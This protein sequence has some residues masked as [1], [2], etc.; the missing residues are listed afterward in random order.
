MVKDKSHINK[1]L[2]IA[3]ILILFNILTRVI[4][5]E[6][7]EWPIFVFASIIIIG[8]TIAIKIHDKN[9][10][11]INSFGLL[12]SYGFKIAAVIAC[13]YF[14]YLILAINI[15]F[16]EFINE[17][18]NRKLIE[19]KNQ[20]LVNGNDQTKNLESTVAMAKKVVTYTYLAGTLIG[21]LFI[22]VIG[23]TIGSVI[24]TKNK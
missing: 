22:G 3:V 2:I 23:S 12:F 9:S 21:T 15:F 11:S 4:N 6:F 1:G 13:I 5:A 24:V 20:G 10:N 19:A 7:S 17:M 18:I 8:I 16:P 14:I